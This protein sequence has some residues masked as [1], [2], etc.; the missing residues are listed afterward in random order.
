MLIDFHTHVFPN[1]IAARTIDILKG[2]MRKEYGEHEAYTDGTLKDLRRLMDEDGV[3]I[4]VTMPIATKVTQTE[5]INNYAMEITDGKSI[6]SFASLHPMQKN[7]EETLESI[8]EKGFLGIKLHPD[9][10]DFFIDS[11]ESIKILKKAEQL[12][13]IVMLHAGV[14]IGMPPP[15]HCHPKRLKNALTEVSGEKIIAAHMGGFDL[16]DDVEK[17]LVGTPIYFDTSMACERLSTEQCRRMIK[18]HG[19]EKILFA[20]DTPW[21][22]ASTTL[23]YLNSLGL[24]EEELKLITHKNAEKLLSL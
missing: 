3:D 4:G 1:A 8:K 6:I 13:L 9:Y 16:W 10:Q 19:A 12:D 23:N 7:V 5:S 14:D 2:K 15:V 11:D 17:Y 22:K 24:T 18:N 20:S 21:Q